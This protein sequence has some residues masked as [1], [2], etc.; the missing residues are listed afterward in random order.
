[1]VSLA[2]RVQHDDI[3]RLERHLGLPDLGYQDISASLELDR[4]I[5]RWPLLTELSIIAD[6]ETAFDSVSL[7]PVTAPTVGR[8]PV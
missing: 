2:Q 6:L 8:Q 5:Q 4:A 7:E 1:M 3:A